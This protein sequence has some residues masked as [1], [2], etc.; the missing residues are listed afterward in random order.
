MGRTKKTASKVGSIFIN[1]Q[2]HFNTMNET[3]EFTMGETTFKYHKYLTF[4][5][6]IEA[7]KEYCAMVIVYDE[8]EN[9]SHLAYLDRYAEA[10]VFTKYFT[11][12]PLYE[13]DHVANWIIVN[14]VYDIVTK[15]EISGD[16]DLYWGLIRSCNE[17]IKDGKSKNTILSKLMDMVD[18]IS[19]TIS[20]A[21]NR[22][23]SMTDEELLSL[24]KGEETKETTSDILKIEEELKDGRSQGNAGETA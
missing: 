16:I 22:I 6:Y 10:Y 20:G 8:H 17:I 3:K 9:V 21:T 11:D 5:K 14:S 18:T 23:K 15:D 1:A 4:D 19:N 12:V 2:K 24:A 7:A 13:E